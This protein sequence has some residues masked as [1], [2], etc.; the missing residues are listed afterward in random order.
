[1]KNNGVKSISWLEQVVLD[2]GELKQNIL[3]KYPSAT[4]T[5]PGIVMQVVYHTA[6][7][8]LFIGAVYA[9]V[10]LEPD[11]TTLIVFFMPGFL[12]ITRFLKWGLRQLDEIS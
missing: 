2:D 5:E 12:A 3:D 11:M 6:A 1:M 4:S 9:I 10:W 8:C 7:I